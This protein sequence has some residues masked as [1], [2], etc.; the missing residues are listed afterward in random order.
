MA[1]KTPARLSPHTTANTT[2][3]APNVTASGTVITAA[4]V[5]GAVALAGEAAVHL[6]QYASL[7]HHVRWLGPLFLLNAAIATAAAGGLVLSPTRTLAA[8][9]GVATSAVALAALIV[10]YGRGLFGWTETG[11]RTPVEFAVITETAAVILLSL[12]LAA[13]L[14]ERNLGATTGAPDSYAA[15]VGD[16]HSETERISSTN[17]QNHAA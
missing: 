9:T 11:F 15:T 12:A 4:Y 7:L 5:L 1:T 8:L 2:T 13:A 10:S 14:L 16:L 3:T 17:V 6:Q